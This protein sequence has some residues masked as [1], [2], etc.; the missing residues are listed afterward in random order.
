MKKAAVTERSWII[1]LF[2]SIQLPLL[3]MTQNWK[4][5]L[6]SMG[7]P[8]LNMGVPSNYSHLVLNVLKLCSVSQLPSFLWF[9][10]SSACNSTWMLWALLVGCL[11]FFFQKDRR[12]T[13]NSSHSTSS[14]SRRL[15]RSKSILNTYHFWCFNSSPPHK[16]IQTSIKW[17]VFSVNLSGALSVTSLQTYSFWPDLLV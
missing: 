9:F 11:F 8:T 15:P 6:R 16:A 7:V 17:F 2:F 12:K 1:I 3:K 14:V 4:N 5:W 13:V 10:Y